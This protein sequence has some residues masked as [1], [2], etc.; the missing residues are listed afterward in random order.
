MKT[1]LCAVDGTESAEPALEFAIE[2]SQ[3]TH[4]ELYT[5]AVKPSVIEGRGSA[6][7]VHPFDDAHGAAAI[8]DAA[9][10]TAR[11]AGVE[12]HAS[13]AV[14]HT[15]E[16]IATAAERLEADLVVV[17]SRRLGRVSSAVRGSV[18]HALAR[19]CPVPVTVV[20]SPRRDADEPRHAGS[21]QDVAG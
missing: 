13:L 16:E 10:S 18:S 2:M 17:G 14:G 9:A 1:I 8:A 19:R 20:A 15:V 5:I 4:A 21:P 11:A 12:A 3:A 6:I 7:A